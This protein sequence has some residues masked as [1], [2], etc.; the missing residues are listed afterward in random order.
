MLST[1]SAKL[2]EK[3]VTSTLSKG[4]NM[5][6]LDTNMYHLGVNKVPLSFCTLRYHPSDRFVPFFLKVC[7]NLGSPVACSLKVKEKSFLTV[8]SCL[9]VSTSVKNSRRAETKHTLTHKE[10]VCVNIICVLLCT[11]LLLPQWE[12]E[13]G[14]LWISPSHVS[15]FHQHTHTHTHT[16]PMRSPSLWCCLKQIFV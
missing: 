10:R 11:S 12:L 2:S 15:D 6:N 4:T 13:T 8:T 5:F 16:Q 14:A 7:I 3:T 9:K 1:V